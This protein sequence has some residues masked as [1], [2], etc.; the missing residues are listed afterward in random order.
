[1]SKDPDFK[2]TFVKVLKA[3]PREA[4]VKD[5][6]WV[7]VHVSKVALHLNGEVFPHAE[8]LA[9]SDALTNNCLTLNA[10]FDEKKF[11]D[12]HN[13]NGFTLK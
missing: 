7:L 13:T 12:K 1:M 2:M 3:A 9:K 5:P 4:M 10:D 6:I 8:H 11:I